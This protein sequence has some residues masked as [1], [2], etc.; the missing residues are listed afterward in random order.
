MISG[1]IIYFEI[2]IFIFNKNYLQNIYTVYSHDLLIFDEF[3]YS[4]N[5]LDEHDWDDYQIN[6]DYNLHL[7]D[8]DINPFTRR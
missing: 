6:H 1:F 8:N 7:D 2:N 3:E 5:L 4:F